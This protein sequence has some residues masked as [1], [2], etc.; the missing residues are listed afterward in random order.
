LLTAIRK[1][2]A[3][4]A[5]FERL[6]PAGCLIPVPRPLSTALNG[7]RNDNDPVLHEDVWITPSTG[8]IPRWLDDDDV[9]DGIRSLHIADRCAEEA[10]RLTLER[11]NLARWLAQERA[12]I[13]RAIASSTGVLLSFFLNHDTHFW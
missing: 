1:F 3:Y 6:R 5:D 7:L 11:Q 13:T 8:T 2:N 10:L 12:I 4:C 9:R